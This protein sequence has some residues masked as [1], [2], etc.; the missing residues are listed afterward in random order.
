MPFAENFMWGGATAANQYEGGYQE[1]G[2]GLSTMDVRLPGSRQKRR[3]ASFIQ[4]DGRITFATRFEPAGK[5]AR[6]YMIPGRYYPSHTAVDF[7]HHWKEDIA[8]FAEMGFR[9]FRMSISWSRLFPRGDEETPNPEGVEFY[10]NVFEELQ[11][12]HIEPLVTLNHFELPM[13]LADEYDGWLDRRTVDY[14]ARFTEVCFREYKGLVRYWKTFN[15][16]N[17]MKD[18]TKLGTKDFEYETIEQAVYHV[19]LGSA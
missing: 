13:F 14:F 18:W 7:Y 11:K 10:R 4:P 9:C 17:V 2:R 3:A 6:G 15:E 1:G 19:L 16:I 5:G 8:L 12:H